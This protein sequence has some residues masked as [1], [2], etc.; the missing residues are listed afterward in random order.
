LGVEFALYLGPA[1]APALEEL[2]LS[3]A[4]FAVGAVIGRR[5]ASS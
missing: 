1:P 3:A 4:S 2:I 5:K